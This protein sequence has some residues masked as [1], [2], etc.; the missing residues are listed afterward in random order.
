MQYIHPVSFCAFG[1]VEPYEK[2][3]Y[4]NIQKKLCNSKTL[5]V[6]IFSG[7]GKNGYFFIYYTV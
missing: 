5:D 2:I 7:S 4:G 3:L 6:H 1:L